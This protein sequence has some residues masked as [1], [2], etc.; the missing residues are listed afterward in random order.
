[1]AVEDLRKSEM[2]AHLIDALDQG[3]DIGHYGKLVFAHSGTSLSI[4][5]S[6]DSV[7]DPSAGL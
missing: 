6:V 5:R 3:E 4:G 7:F 1:M 2:M